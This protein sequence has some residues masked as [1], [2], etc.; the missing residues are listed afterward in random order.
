MSGIHDRRSRFPAHRYHRRITERYSARSL[1]LGPFARL[2]GILVLR[3]LQPHQQTLVRALPGMSIR[4]L[5]IQNDARDGRIALILPHADRDD[6]ALAYF[7]PVLRHGQPGVRQI[8]DQPRRRVQKLNLRDYA[9]VGKHLDR[10]SSL[11]LYNANAAD[12]PGRT[13]ILAGHL[14]GGEGQH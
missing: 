3:R 5:Q 6:I 1:R 7:N 8:D 4:R 11:F 2:A 13:K 9:R 10:G 14:Q 12:L